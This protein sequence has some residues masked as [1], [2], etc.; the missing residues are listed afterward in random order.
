M[1]IVLQYI[2]NRML[3]TWNIMIYVNYTSVKYIKNFKFLNKKRKFNTLNLTLER[4]K[5]TQIWSVDSKVFSTWRFP[6]MSNWRH[7]LSCVPS[8]R[9][10][11]KHK[12]QLLHITYLGAGSQLW[13]REGGAGVRRPCQ[14]PWVSCRGR[15]YVEGSN[16]SNSSWHL[17]GTKTWRLV[18]CKHEWIG[19]P[20]E[21]L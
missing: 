1:L 9:G 20:W 13:H 3:Y 2:Q 6:V 19:E 16:A 7:V 17:Q 11:V 21:F 18:C 5:Q 12:V 4:Q 8:D 10:S 15:L 14:P